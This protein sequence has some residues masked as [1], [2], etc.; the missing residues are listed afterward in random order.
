MRCLSDPATQ[1]GNFYGILC[2]DCIVG[3]ITTP[4]PHFLIGDIDE[5]ESVIVHHS[6]IHRPLTRTGL[7]CYDGDTIQST[8]T[9]YMPLSD[10]DDDTL[11]QSDALED[12]DLS[13]YRHFD[14]MEYR[15]ISSN[16]TI[17]TSDSIYSLNVLEEE[18]KVLQNATHHDKDDKSI[19]RCLTRYQSCIG[20][21]KDVDKKK[22]LVDE[23]ELFKSR[24][25]AD[26][27][28]EAAKA[29]HYRENARNNGYNHSNEN[30]IVFYQ[31]AIAFT[32]DLEQKNELKLEYR[33]FCFSIKGGGNTPSSSHD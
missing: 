22:Q 27:E 30:R 19:R 2:C 26:N 5:A 12:P 33:R 21:V 3:Y 14:T 18:R 25:D 8:I 13:Y 32:N 16:S 23:Y 24:Y 7:T 15:L 28:E 9:S 10:D 1:I 11:N 4:T 29:E 20:T 31:R 17:T 6:G